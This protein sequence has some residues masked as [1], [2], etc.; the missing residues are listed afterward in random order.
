[1]KVI[2]FNASKKLKTRLG[3]FDI[4]YEAELNKSGLFDIVAYP[5]TVVINSNGIVIKTDDGFSG[6]V[7]EVSSTDFSN[8]IIS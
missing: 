1:M 4:K 7:F 3:V 2:F 8:M 6:H 5:G